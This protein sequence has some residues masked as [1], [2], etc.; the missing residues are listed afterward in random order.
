MEYWKAAETLGDRVY[1]ENV[2]HWEDALVET[3]MSPASSLPLPA[4][5]LL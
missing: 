1:L 2:G 4:V 3:I 5:K